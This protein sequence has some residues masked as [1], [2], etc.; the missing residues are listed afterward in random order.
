M[1][2]ASSRRPNTLSAALRLRMG[3]HRRW[4]DESSRRRRHVLRSAPRRRIGQRRGQRGAVQPAPGRRPGR[5]GPFSDPYRGRSD[6]DLINDDVVGTQQA[7]FPT[8]VLVSTFGD[9]YKVPLTYNYNLTFERELFSGL[10]ARAGTSDRATA[11]DASGLSLNYADK[12]IPGATT[13]N[14]DARRLFAVGQPRPD[15]LAGAGPL[16]ELQLDAA[17]ADQAVLAWL[18][19]YK[20]LHG[21]E[22]R[23]RLRRRAH[24]VQPAA[25]SGAG[26]GPARPGSSSSLHH[27][28]GLGSPGLQRGSDAVGA[29]RL[30]VDGRHAIPDG[31]SVHGCQRHGQL[32]GRH[33]QRPREADGRV[34]RTTGRARRRPCGS[35]ARLSR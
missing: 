23:R 2:K 32:S 25:G 9:E 7:P 29:R 13:G 10:M 16:V 30:A 12:N 20:Q 3:H 14:T 17:C 4:Q 24:S 26:V 34:G 35:T 5:Q 21:V 15:R 28:V 6:F 8:P 27:V 11:T 22:S 1:K 19:D 33:R 31:S 18:H